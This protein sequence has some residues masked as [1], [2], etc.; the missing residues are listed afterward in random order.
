MGRK[1]KNSNLRI[2]IVFAFVVIVAFSLLVAEIVNFINRQKEINVARQENLKTDTVA[3]E[4]VKVPEKFDSFIKNLKYDTEK[5]VEN[6]TQTQLIEII[7]DSEENETKLDYLKFLD[8]AN[9]EDGAKDVV[10]NKVSIESQSNIVDKLVVKEDDEIF[11]GVNCKWRSV[12][13]KGDNYFDS[14]YIVPKR[15]YFN[16]KANTLNMDDYDKAKRMLDIMTLLD[17]SQ[18]NLIQSFFIREDDGCHYDVYYITSL[19][20]EADNANKYSLVKETTIVDSASGLI[21]EPSEVVLKEF[22]H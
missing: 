4:E 16:T 1:K 19:Y 2:I 3:V 5:D 15:E 14:N 12:T 18:Y 22:I 8:C 10:K 7:D 21:G 13:P 17:K 9:T 20:S 6:L 11:Y